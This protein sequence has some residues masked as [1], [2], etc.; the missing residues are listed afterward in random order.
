MRASPGRTNRSA[1]VGSVLDCWMPLLSAVVAVRIAVTASERAGR[2]SAALAR[3]LYV[4]STLF[5]WRALPLC[6]GCH[7]V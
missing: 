6:A 7:L 3:E 2:P 4:R 1:Y 5:R